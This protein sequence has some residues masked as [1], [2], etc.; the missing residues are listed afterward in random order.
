[1]NY[2]G[3]PI[4]VAITKEVAGVAAATSMD[5]GPAAGELWIVQSLW[6]WHDDAN[7]QAL[8][9]RIT[10][11]VTPIV[12][13]A[14]AAVAQNTRMPFGMVSSTAGWQGLNVNLLPLVLSENLKVGLDAGAMTA[15]KKLYIA[16]V[17]YVIRGMGSYSNA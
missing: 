14:Q 12:G 4:G 13:N 2:Y 17:V 7:P 11:G 8:N 3:L 10:D 1:M 6:G 5:F 9:W 15:G 16:G